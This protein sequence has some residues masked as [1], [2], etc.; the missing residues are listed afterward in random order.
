MKHP[1]RRLVDTKRVPTRAMD[2]D[3]VTAADCPPHPSVLLLTLYYP[4]YIGGIEI[5]TQAVAVALA[6]AGARVSV[7]CFSFDNHGRM[8][9]HISHEG[10]IDV[11]RMAPRLGL[12]W[13][14]MAR[15]LRSVRDSVGVLHVQGYSRPLLLLV[16]LFRRRGTWVITPHGLHNAGRDDQ[17]RLGV[18]LA[19]RL[20]DALL[21]PWL[22]NG[23]AFIF[24]ISTA[25]RDYVHRR[26]RHPLNS[27]TVI[28]GSP[29]DKTNA[30]LVQSADHT[31]QRFLTLSRLTARKRLSDLVRV[32]VADPSLPGCDLAGPPGDDSQRLQNLALQ[33]SSHQIAFLGPVAGRRKLFLLRSAL[34]LV[35]CSDYEGLSVA[36]LEALAQGTPVVASTGAAA[37]LPISGVITYPTGDLDALAA[38]L[39]AVATPDQQRRLRAEA[40]A[41]GVSL[42][43]ARAYAHRLLEYY[44]SV[45]PH[46]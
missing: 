32:L 46:D 22:L 7:A 17:G 42:L 16:R 28:L 10:S 25:E 20:I 41:V 12:R 40:A 33:G 30:D 43:D 26:L 21:L 1:P 13:L 31:P 8:S 3:G 44:A 19:R 45:L 18:T 6:D 36:A 24:A 39:R 23:A 27:K 4:P 29:I 37:G 38:A 11:V 2:S 9:S 14:D 5:H 35:L 15:Y 34:A